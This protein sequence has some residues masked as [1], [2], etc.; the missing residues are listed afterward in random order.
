LVYHKPL[1]EKNATFCGWLAIAIYFSDGISALMLMF[2]DLEIQ[3]LHPFST[4]N[5]QQ[6][7]GN[8]PGL[9]V[10]S[11]QAIRVITAVFL[12]LGFV[13]IYI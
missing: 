2:F 7:E 13:Y 8:Q 4:L 9:C 5:L 12:Q 10:E 6:T 1:N 11:T 3:K